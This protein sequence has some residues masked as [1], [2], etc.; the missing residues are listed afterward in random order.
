MKQAIKI[1]NKLSAII[2]KKVTFM[3]L[4][5]HEDNNHMDRG[6]LHI[7]LVNICADHDYQSCTQTTHPQF[8]YLELTLKLIPTCDPDRH[9]PAIDSSISIT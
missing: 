5:L 2:R 6:G 7:Q 3:P 8:S 1:K 9:Q 4:I